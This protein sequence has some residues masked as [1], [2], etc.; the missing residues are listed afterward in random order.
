MKNKI[1]LIK[2][3]ND[4]D[5]YYDEH[6]GFVVVAANEEAARQMCVYDIT[7]NGEYTWNKHEAARFL[8]P[9]VTSCEEITSKHP[10]GILLEDF[11][12]G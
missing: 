12:A 5:V 2:H 3:I 1:F 10:A 11:H 9:A 8:D 4:D 6:A 7:D